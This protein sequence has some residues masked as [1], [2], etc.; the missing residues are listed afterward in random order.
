MLHRPNLP[1]R[2]EYTC[3]NMVPAQTGDEVVVSLNYGVAVNIHAPNFSILK[4]IRS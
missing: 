2:C 4:Q 3:E 1:K